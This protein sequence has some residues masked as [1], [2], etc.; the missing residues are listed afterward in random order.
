MTQRVVVTGAAG[1][2]PLGTHWDDVKTKLLAKTS[3]VTVQPG[4]EDV[5]GLRTRLGAV[6]SGFERPAHYPRKKVRTMG[7][8]ALL[9]TR[10]T[11]L[12]LEAA[13][14]LDHEA[15]INGQTGISYGST[16]GS[17]PAIRHFVEQVAIS[18]TMAGITGAQFIQYM[19]HTCAANLAQFFE[20]KGRVIPTC[21]A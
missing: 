14:L 10:A 4:W 5:E 19:S 6:I 13:G 17:P 9:A 11:E 2:C 8:V 12:A 18:K 7:R 15:L 21:S 20:A 3:S 1:L 16:S